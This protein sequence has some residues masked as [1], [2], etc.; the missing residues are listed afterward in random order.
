[1][2]STAPPTAV[3][4]PPPSPA[5]P[6]TPAPTSTSLPPTTAIY[7]L[8][9]TLSHVYTHVHTPLLLS[10][11]FFSL[12]CLVADPITSLTYGAAGLAL[13]QS[14]Y[15]AI[16][17][18]PA[19]GGTATK[20][21][22]KKKTKAKAGPPGIQ[23]KKEEDNGWTGPALDIA[24]RLAFSLI[25][26]ILF[27]APVFLAAIL[28]GAPLTT[29]LP[30][31]TL[32]TLHIALLALFPLLYARPLSSRHWLEILSFT[33]PLDEVFGAAAGTLIG[34]WLGAIPIPLDWDRPWQT[35]PIT[36]AVGA[37]VGWGIGRQA[38]V[39]VAGRWRGKW[40]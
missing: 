22:K 35:W 32:L 34:S 39:L 31:T 8:N 20:K 7:K 5:A 14:A 30:H 3:A 21:K 1:M 16:C 26:T 13:I 23:A 4:K 12:P 19:L 10:T 11:V 40:D 29:H 27:A 24:Y 2:P 38:G 36:I 25:L 6:A 9:T 33:A 18:Q 28:L 17:L 37:Y 15:C